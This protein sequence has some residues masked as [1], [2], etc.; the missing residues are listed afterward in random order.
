MPSAADPARNVLFG[1]AAE[2]A[3]LD[4]VLDALLA[5]RARPVFLRGAC[6]VGKSA[7]LDETAGRAE[8]MGIQV[9]RAA[10]AQS[11]AGLAFSGL[12]QLVH[13]L[14]GV[15]PGLPDAQRESLDRAL[16]V[17]RGAPPDRFA[18]SA[19]A[20]ALLREVADN[21][22]VLLIV[23]DAQWMDRASAEVL[24]FVARRLGRQPIGL[25]AAV[26]AGGD[27]FLDHGGCRETLLEPLDPGAAAA[28]LEARHPGLAPAAR[29]RLLAEAAGNPLALLE[30]PALLSERQLSGRAELPEWLPLNERLE[31]LFAAGIRGLP[32]DTKDLLLLAALERTGSVR[33]IWSASR[34]GWTEADAALV[35]GERA[36]LVRVDTHG[37]QLVFRHP[38]VRSAIVQAVSGAQRRIAHRALAEALDAEPDRQVGHL[39]LASLGPNEDTA[40]ALEAAAR[41]ASHYGAPDV[42][43]NALR[44]AAELSTGTED[45]SRRLS[46]AALIAGRA[47]RTEEAAE[48]LESAHWEDTSPEDAARASL[49]HAY[50]MIEH[51][52]DTGAAYEALTR[53]LDELADGER[54]EAGQHP[55]EGLV[56]EILYVLMRTAAHSGRAEWWGPPAARLSGASEFSRLYFDTSGDPARRGHTVRRRLDGVLGALAHEPGSGRFLQL[57]LAAARLGIP[58]EHRNVWRRVLERTHD[59]GA[60]TNWATAVTLSG[61]EAFHSGQWDTVESTVQEALAEAQELGYRMCAGQLKGLLALVHG[62]RG[63]TDSLEPIAEELTSWAASHGLGT[64][65]QSVWRARGLAALAHGDHDSAYTCFLRITPAGTFRPYAP[66]AVEAVMDLVEAAVRSGRTGEARAHVAAARHACL[67]DLSPRSLLLVAGSQ[68]LAAPAESAAAAF[69]EVL[70]LPE[71]DQWPF[72]RARLQLAYGRVLRSNGSADLAAHHLRAAQETLEWLGASPWAEQARA[73]LHSTG[74]VPDSAEENE[75]V[76]LTAQETQIARLAATGLSNKQIASQLFLSHR[77]VSTH[78]YNLF[79]KLKITSRAALRDALKQA[80]LG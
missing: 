61:V 53:A 69:E 65:Q 78:L 49:A 33:T 25:L 2:R 7:L 19:A 55:E 70:S 40:R 54:R 68:A 63:R 29:Q 26:R 10:G 73:E 50:R 34:G 44:H 23:D 76:V 52:A 17:T 5:G 13:S 21:G 28:L 9:L 64:A 36:G 27:G 62:A 31:T 60:F 3:M 4:G 77:T 16:G 30:L 71:A 37:T 46:R 43:L 79:P 45:R 14:R 38:L 22:P 39:I 59:G 48:I 72:E 56:D 74:A 41:N 32:D 12:H 75:P 1:R 18:I 42:A 51:D 6:G 24:E 58:S 11:E 15:C 8:A 66:V 57:S 35:P 47:G 67:A 80:G 20:L